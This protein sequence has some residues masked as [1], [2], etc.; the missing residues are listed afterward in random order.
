MAV[1][2]SYSICWVVPYNIFYF[3]YLEKKYFHSPLNA[4]PATTF[5]KVGTSLSQSVNPKVSKVYGILFSSIT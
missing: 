4:C 2:F 3:F 5:V 1:T